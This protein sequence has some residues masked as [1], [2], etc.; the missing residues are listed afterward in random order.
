MERTQR[1]YAKD[2]NARVTAYK[3]TPFDKEKKLRITFDFDKPMT[4]RERQD[5][6][7]RRKL[8]T[9]RWSEEQRHRA[10]QKSRSKKA[11][12]KQSQKPET[13]RDVVETA[14]RE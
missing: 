5:E 10:Q 8:F 13:W 11:K 9:H 2:R 3:K 7:S 1:K 12:N 4:M 14:W 6:Q